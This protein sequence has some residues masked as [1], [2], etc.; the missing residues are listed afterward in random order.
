MVF[1]KS[2]LYPIVA[3]IWARIAL[4]ECD[5][6]LLLGIHFRIAARDVAHLHS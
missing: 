3:F 4:V 6:L 2:L 1:V 5:F